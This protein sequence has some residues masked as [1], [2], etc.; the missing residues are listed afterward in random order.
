MW[1]SSLCC[2]RL[3][4][5]LRCS[6]VRAVRGWCGAHHYGVHGYILFCVVVAY[7][8]FTMGAVLIIMAFTVISILCCS[9]MR[10]VRCGRGSDHYGVH[11]FILFC[12]VVAYALFAVGAV[13]IIMVFTVIYYFVL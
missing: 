6:G 1:C 10:A 9:G 11:G 3:Y 4:T 13:H 7:L 5:I 12:F 2:S 8:L